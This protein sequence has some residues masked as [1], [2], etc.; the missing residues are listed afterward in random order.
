MI[1][2]QIIIPGLLWTLVNDTM[3]IYWHLPT[4]KEVILG[5]TDVKQTIG[6]ER[7]AGCSQ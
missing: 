3:E 5:N 6:V 7:T 1:S 2:Y 4:S